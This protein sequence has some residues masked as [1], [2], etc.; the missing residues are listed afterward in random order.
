MRSYKEK[1]TK[2]R[3]A[4]SIETRANFCVTKST[5][6]VKIMRELNFTHTPKRPNGTIILNL[7]IAD[8]I[9]DT[10]I[11]IN[12]FS[13]FGLLIPPNMPFSIRLVGCSYNNVS[14]AVL[15]CEIQ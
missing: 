1:S 14:T 6:K 2:I 15:H 5:R 3:L 7:R 10:N 8:I 11:C 4:I 9:I 12:R 13:C